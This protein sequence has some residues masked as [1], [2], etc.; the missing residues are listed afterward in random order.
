MM[1]FGWLCGDMNK[2]S[3]WALCIGTS[4]CLITDSHGRSLPLH[5]SWFNKKACME[6]SCTGSTFL[7]Q[8]ST[9]NFLAT[10]VALH[11]LGNSL[12]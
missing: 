12:N 2:Q 11:T 3:V 7:V 4:Q 9:F 5:L 1:M 8:H 6:S 10:L